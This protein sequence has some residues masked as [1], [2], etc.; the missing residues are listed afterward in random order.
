MDSCFNVNIRIHRR[1]GIAWHMNVAVSLGLMRN[2]GVNESA[3]ENLEHVKASETPG[4]FTS[5]K[6]LGSVAAESVRRR[7]T[8]GVELERPRDLRGCVA[9]NPWVFDVATSLVSTNILT[10][11]M[12]VSALIGWRR[13]ARSSLRRNVL[14]DWAGIGRGQPPADTPRRSKAIHCGPGV[15]LRRP[16]PL[17]NRAR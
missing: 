17:P 10:I 4:W 9:S 14:P 11:V 7:C 6:V 12:V 16:G 13:P 8:G 3:L 15:H 1:Y 2:A 5:I